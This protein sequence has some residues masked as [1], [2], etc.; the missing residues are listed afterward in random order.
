[1]L[2][3]SH[4]HLAEDDYR[5]DLVQVVREAEEAG[6]GCMVVPATDP[7]S[8]SRVLE[9]GQQFASLFPAL[10]VQ[11][12]DAKT[13]VPDLLE[14]L[15]HLAPSAV[16]IGEIG[17]DF[18]YDLSP[19]PSQI[20]CFRAHLQLARDLSLPVILH[21]RDAEEEFLRA[22]RE[23]GVPQGGVVHCCTCAWEYAK[24]FLDLGLHLGVTGMVTFPKLVNV[25]AIARQCPLERLLIE[26]DGPY[27]APVPHRGERNR[28]AFVAYV[29]QTIAKLR[30]ME[31]SEVAQITSANA[32]RLFGIRLADRSHPAS[33]A[34]A[35]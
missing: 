14:E 1:M 4:V 8:W 6:V 3:D 16:A 17:L 34:T 13:Y 28:P 25:H 32:L 30:D 5:E 9:L 21:C 2:V 27:L 20:T 10:G 11:P 35:T 15:R 12:H 7:Q 26:T 22:L 18:H 19:R 31:S 24:Q 33:N 23:V 29:A